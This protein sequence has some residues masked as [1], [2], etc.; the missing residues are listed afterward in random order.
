M[1][2]EWF[3][4]GKELCTDSL[5]YKAGMWELSVEL[6]L[7]AELNVALQSKIYFKQ[8]QRKRKK[9]LREKKGRVAVGVDFSIYRDSVSLFLYLRLF[10]FYQTFLVCN[11][12]CLMLTTWM[13]EWAENM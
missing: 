1:T 9:N 5:D 10:H 3:L 8:I 7:S 11:S 2:W 12:L 4:G 6:K 13:L